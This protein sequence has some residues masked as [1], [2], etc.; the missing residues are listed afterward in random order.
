MERIDRFF[1]PAMYRKSFIPNSNR[2]VLI[3]KIEYYYKI[4]TSY[5][6]SE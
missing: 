5:Y 3:H 1:S 6:I 4:D 2:D